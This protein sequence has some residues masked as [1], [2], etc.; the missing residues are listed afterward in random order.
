VLAAATMPAPA[1][2]QAVPRRKIVVRLREHY[3]AVHELSEQGMSKAA[4][5]PSPLGRGADRQD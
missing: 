3:A 2:V 4:S 5:P 1:L